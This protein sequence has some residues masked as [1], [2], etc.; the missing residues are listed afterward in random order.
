MSM[1]MPL[2]RPRQCPVT[3]QSRRNLGC[4]VGCRHR[5][6]RDPGDVYPCTPQLRRGNSRIDVE[7]VCVATCCAE[8][9]RVFRPTEAESGCDPGLIGRPAFGLSL[10]RRRKSQVAAPAPGIEI[11]ALLK[12]SRNWLTRRSTMRPSPVPFGVERLTM[13]LFRRLGW[14]RRWRRVVRTEGAAAEV[15]PRGGGIQIDGVVGNVELEMTVFD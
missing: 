14:C 9:S 6:R 7:E 2:N 8:E 13:T 10:C 5:S 1:G 3:F 11:V 12:L 4:P 15:C